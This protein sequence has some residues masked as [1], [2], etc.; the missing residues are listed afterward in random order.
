MIQP[1]V[2]GHGEVPAVPI[3]LRKL[4]ELM[5]I[6]FVRIGIPIRSKRSQLTQEEG[7]KR[8]IQMAR[9]QPGCKAILVMFDAD[10]DCPKENVPQWLQWAQEAAKPLPCSL[11]LPNKEYE[12][13]FL[14]CLGSLLAKR[15]INPVYAYDKD[16][17]SKRDAKGELEA[18]F[19]PEFHY[20]ETADQPSL[21]ARADWALVHER[22]RSFRKM[23]KEARLLFLAD[24][25]KPTSW[26]S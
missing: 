5:G 22:S 25:L 9:S 8:Y 2:E 24:G 4:A 18:H 7:L 16:S 13:W 12:G 1:V 23:V 15:G 3:L 14:A 6:P 11:V 19:G 20:L 17:E 21:T 26:P 10:D